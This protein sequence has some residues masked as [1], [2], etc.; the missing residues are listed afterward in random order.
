MT[1]SAGPPPH[2]LATTDI[3]QPA[4]G[5]AEATVVAR[6]RWLPEGPG[7]HCGVL[8]VATVMQYEIVRV[9]SG[10]VAGKNLF[11]AHGCAELPRAQYR[12][13]AGTLTAFRVGELHRLVLTTSAP[14][15]GPTLMPEPALPTFFCKQVDPAL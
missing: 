11:V 13:G 10:R 15:D 1:H 3:A 2:A 5:S 14:N 6:L 12:Q 4:N 8:H 7:F 9:E